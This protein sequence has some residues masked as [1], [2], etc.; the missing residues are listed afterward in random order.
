MNYIDIAHLHNLQP[1]LVVKSIQSLLKLFS[2]NH[3][4]LLELDMIVGKSA[5][6]LRGE[7]ETDALDRGA[8]DAWNKYKYCC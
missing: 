3:R 7:L 8:S 1:H 4:L 5:V 6:Q 2:V